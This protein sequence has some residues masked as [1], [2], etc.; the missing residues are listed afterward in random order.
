MTSSSDFLPRLRT[1]II[2][3]GDLLIRSPTEVNAGTLQTIESANRKVKL[4]NGHLKN[5][6]LTGFF[7]LFHDLGGIHTQS[8][9]HDARF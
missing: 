6:I 1:F 8:E 5:L 3:S 4:F 9:F 2:S 7:L